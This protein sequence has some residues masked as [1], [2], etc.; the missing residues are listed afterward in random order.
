MRNQDGQM[1]S[2]NYKKE[3]TKLMKKSKEIAEIELRLEE[4][5]NEKKNLK[6][7]IDSINYQVSFLR[8]L[9]TKKEAKLT[10]ALNR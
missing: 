7:K 1:N 6:R 9:K 10:L 5:R 8:E 4:L 2:M 3:T